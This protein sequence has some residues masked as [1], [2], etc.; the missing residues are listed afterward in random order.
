VVHRDLKP[1]NILIAG[2][3]TPKLLD[4]GVAKLL[5]GE[6]DARTVLQT[7]PFTPDYASPEQVR[8]LPVT[9]S[10]DIYSLGAVLYELLAGQGPHPITGRTA[11]AVERAVCEAEIARP[12]AMAPQLD[13]DLENIIM[14]ALRKEPDRRY[15][16]VDQFA[17]DIRRYLEGRAVLAC[18][19]T[20]VYRARKFL[21]RHWW[22]AAAGFVVFASLTAATAISLVQSRRAEGRR[23]EAV[24]ERLRAQA[25]SRSADAAR[26]AE[27]EQRRVAEQQGQEAERQRGI[28]EQRISELVDL[29]NRTLFDVHSAIEPL[30]GAVAARRKIIKTTLDYLERLEKDSGQ[31]E[32]VRVALSDAYLKIGKIQG[33][34][35]GPSMG[36]FEGARLSFA[37]AGAL[38]APFYAT[39]SGDSGLMLRWISIQ[40]H[41]ADLV[42]RAGKSQAAVE[43]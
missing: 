1:G 40:Y 43:I 22:E 6:A 15:Q 21:R 27:A 23:V 41:S 33:D 30:P 36:D 34:A 19:D 42:Y 16:S 10:T 12:R 9:T 37:K 11:V 8:G 28:A 17:E 13:P 2:D 38:L 35:Y 29:A 31:D 5:D 7:R 26:R 14:F 18:E 39:R 32:R 3:G 20:F 24:R 25:E 4:F